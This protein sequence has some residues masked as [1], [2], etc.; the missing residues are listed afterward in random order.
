MPQPHH[1]KVSW[2]RVALLTLRSIVGLSFLILAWSCGTVP[3]LQDESIDN[4]IRVPF[5]RVLVAQSAQ[6]MKVSADKAFAIEFLDGDK[7]EVFYSASPIQIRQNFDRLNVYDYNG[8]EIRTGAT[9]VN[10]IPRGVGNRLALNKKRYRGMLRFLPVGETV[11][12]VN[13]LYMEDYLRGVVPPEIGKR[14]EEEAEAVKAQA[15][16]A[17]T[18]AMSHL[19]QYPNQPYDIKAS[20]MDQV[21]EGASVEN[22]VVNE[23]IDATAGRVIMYQDDLIHAYYHSTCGGYTDNIEDVWDR[24]ELGYLKAVNDGTAG[25]WSK[26]FT[27]TEVFTELQL[28]NR[29]EQ[30]LSGERGRDLRI[31]KITDIIVNDRTPGGR[32]RELIVKTRTDTY[33]FGRDKIR[34]V[35][36]RASNPDLILPSA[37]FDL[38]LDKDANGDVV[39]ATFD[40]HGYGHGVGMCQ[41][42]AIGHAREGWNYDNILTHYYTDVEIRKLY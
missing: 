23:A 14:T 29:L 10:I 6:D 32:I 7:Q 1:L 17:R 37:R 9:E 36:R 2:R 24:G 15:V 30:Y 31:D 12:A 42:G 28:R 35:F 38:K 4:V 20:I 34:W 3:G 27:W 22:R 25:S 11:R 5:V 13:V 41:C 19:R 26:Y 33:R 40:G 16:A 21:Y 18:Y 39:R 8:K